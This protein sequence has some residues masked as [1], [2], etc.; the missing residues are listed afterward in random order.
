MASMEERMKAAEGWIDRADGDLYGRFGE[1][2]L[3]KDYLVSQAEH[4]GRKQLLKTFVVLVGVIQTI[5]GIIVALDKL[6]LLGS[7]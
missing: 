5:V 6:H 2:G 3:V 4:R 7:R 1:P